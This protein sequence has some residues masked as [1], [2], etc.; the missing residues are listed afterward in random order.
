[1][2]LPDN[3]AIFENYII[4]LGQGYIRI[5]KISSELTLTS[6]MKFTDFRR[7]R[8]FFNDGYI[9]LIGFEKGVVLEFDQNNKRL[10]IVGNFDLY[11]NSFSN[12]AFYKD[13]IIV[14]SEDGGKISDI[15]D[16]SDL[17]NIKETLIIPYAG[18]I[19]VD[20]GNGILFIG[21]YKCK[22]YDLNNIE[23]SEVNYL[24]EVNNKSAII[25]IFTSQN[26]NKNFLWLVGETSVNLYSYS[27]NY[28][29]RNQVCKKSNLN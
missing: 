26:Q 20:K 11:Y 6:E 10:K 15:F 27:L 2:N 1:M 25:K 14:S 9:F 18:K 17:N 24:A 21:E 8:F 3:T 12:A 5:F 4:Y 23:N 7:G 29:E 28:T 22:L 13:Y 16:L 19:A